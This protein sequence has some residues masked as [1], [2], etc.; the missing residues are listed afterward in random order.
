MSNSLYMLNS[1]IMRIAVVFLLG[2]SFSA[3]AQENIQ[4]KQQELQG[5]WM[6]VN[7]WAQWCK[8]CREEI[9]ELNRLSVLLE[10]NKIQ[11]LGINYDGIE[12]AELESAIKS[13]DIRFAQMDIS[14]QASINF[15]L[16]AA[17]PA[18]YIVSPSGDVKASLIGKHNLES[19]L[20]ALEDVNPKFV[21]SEFINNQLMVTP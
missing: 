5:E 12:G 6:I 20:I 3:Q 18:T 15:K 16:P 2:V 14:Q 9:P 8:P 21:A 1:A 11:V 17:L 7:F 19:I 10:P 13:L 4:A